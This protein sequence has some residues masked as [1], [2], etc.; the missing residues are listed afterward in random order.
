MKGLA[1]LA[2]LT[3]LSFENEIKIEKNWYWYAHVY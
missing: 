2:N 3:V 1:E